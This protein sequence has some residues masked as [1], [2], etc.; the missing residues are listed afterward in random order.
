METSLPTPSVA[1]TGY[2]PHFRRKRLQRRFIA[3]SGFVLLTMVFAYILLSPSS[4]LSSPSDDNHDPAGEIHRKLLQAGTPKEPEA[5][6][7]EQT[8]E[9]NA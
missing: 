9:A 4:P 3:R 1:R 6:K 8:T 5:G 2:G 7:T